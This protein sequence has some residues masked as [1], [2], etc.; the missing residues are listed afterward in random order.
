MLKHFI[1]EATVCAYMYCLQEIFLVDMGYQFYSTI[2]GV[3]SKMLADDLES[4]AV[5]GIIKKNIKDYYGIIREWY[6]APHKLGNPNREMMVVCPEFY[7]VISNASVFM[8]NMTVGTL[9][10]LCILHHV[11]T[12]FIVVPTKSELI[13]ALP[14]LAKVIS[15]NIDTALEELLDI[16]AIQLKEE[17]CLDPSQNSCV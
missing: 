14:K 1:T 10:A 7:S 3:R 8:S 6:R 16:G 13:S 11:Y 4:M 2:Y 5:L 12:S 9:Q 17:E 15:S